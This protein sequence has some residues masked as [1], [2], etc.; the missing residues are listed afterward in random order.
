MESVSG[1]IYAF[2]ENWGKVAWGALF[3]GSVLGAAILAVRPETSMLWAHGAAGAIG[4][5]AGAIASR[6]PGRAWV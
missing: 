2:L 3:W 4:A 5:A 1:A 6:R